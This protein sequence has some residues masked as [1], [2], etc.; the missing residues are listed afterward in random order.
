MILE[1]SKKRIDR[2]N[3]IK[4]IVENLIENKTLALGSEIDIMSK[5]DYTDLIYTFIYGT[6]SESEYEVKDGDAEIKKDI[7]RY[8]DFEIRRR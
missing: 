1:N 4:K 6:E 2:K 8:K 5:E 3:R 7:Y